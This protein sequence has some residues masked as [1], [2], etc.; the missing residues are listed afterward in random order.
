MLRR[1]TIIIF[2]A[3]MLTAAVSVSAADKIKLSFRS[4]DWDIVLVES[5]L[6]TK[7]GL[8]IEKVA[9]RSGPDAIQALVSGSVDVGSLGETPLASLLSQTD[10]LGVIGTAVNTDGS[11]VKVIVSKDSPLKNINDLKGKKIATTVG[12]GSYRAFSNWCAKNGCSLSDFNI[13]NTTPD[14]ILPAIESGSVDAG[15]WFAPISTISV[16]NGVGRILT[17]LSGAV[18]GQASWVVN[19][20]FAEHNPDLVVRFLAAAI[21]AQNILQFDHERAA[22]L[23][24]QGLRKNGRNLT[25]QQLQPGLTDFNYA[26]IFDTEKSV[27]ILN[28]A[29]NELVAEGKQRGKKPKFEDTMLPQFFSNAQV[30]V[31]ERSN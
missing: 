28:D 5:G 18:D 7:Y 27:R 8:E 12:S 11:Y 10:T 14:S 23:L 26:P 17:N 9:L 16:Q 21:E 20:K 13:F 19:R 15:I 31:A 2:A 4:T 30:M 22:K 1:A 3:L 24:E 29:F 25:A 6:T